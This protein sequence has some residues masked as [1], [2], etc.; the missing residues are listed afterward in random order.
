MPL[1]FWV[2]GQLPGMNEIVDA[3]KGNGGKGYGYAKMKKSW[4]EKVALHALAAHL[5][6]D[7]LKRVRLHMN[8]F[9]P[10]HANGNSRDPDNI[11]AG[12][13]F[14]WDGLVAARILPNDKRANNAGS[15]HVH[16]LGPVPGVEVIITEASDA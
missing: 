5:P 15:T 10:M 3:A 13:K 11:E 8:W 7:K 12:Q 16:S 2:P 6:K 9:E 14:I 1:K 4:T